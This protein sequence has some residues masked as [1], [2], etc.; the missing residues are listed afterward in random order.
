MLGVVELRGR[1][2]GVSLL[3]AWEGSGLSVSGPGQLQLRRGHLLVDS[4]TLHAC[5]REL[6]LSELTWRVCAH[7]SR[8][9]ATR[10]QSGMHRA[11]TRRP[12]SS[13]RYAPDVRCAVSLQRE[14]RADYTHLPELHIKIIAVSYR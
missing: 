7:R 9:A 1:A 6:Q 11:C 10:P 5:V 13:W 12:V 14:S 8:P 4:S 3:G 2:A